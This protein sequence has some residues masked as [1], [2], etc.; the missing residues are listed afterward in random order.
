MFEKIFES[1]EYLKSRLD[2]S[3]LRNRLLIDNLAIA[4]A[5][6]DELQEDVY[7]LEETVKCYREQLESENITPK[8]VTPDFGEKYLRTIALRCNRIDYKKVEL[9]R[10]SIRELEY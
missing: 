1:K 10:E 9:F 3:E 6:I 5:E 2:E 4:M 7:R 8:S